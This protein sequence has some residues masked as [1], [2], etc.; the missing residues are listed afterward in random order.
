MTSPLTERC[1]SVTSSG[2]SSTSTT[3]RWHSGLFVGDRV[4]D[5]LQ[6]HR[7]AG[8][9]RRDDQ[10]ALALADR[11]DEVDDPARQ[12]ARLGL[13]AQ[14]LLRVERGQLAELDAVF[15]ASSGSAPLTVSSRTSALNFSLALALAGLADLRR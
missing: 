14:P 6:D 7:L 10:A 5:R 12:V 11:G 13:Q 3:M 2:R 8:L 9:G 4:G 15:A 1:M